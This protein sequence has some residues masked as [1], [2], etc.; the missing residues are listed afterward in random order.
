MN[1]IMLSTSAS[2]H[3]GPRA[4]WIPLASVAQRHGVSVDVLCLHP[5]YVNLTTQHHRIDDVSIQHVAQMHVD[6]HEQP[7]RG[8]ALISTA[9]RASAQMARHTIRAHPDVIAIC[10]AQPINGLAA[11]IAHR[12]TGAQLILDV[13]DSEHESHQFAR[14]WHKALIARVEHTL[15]HMVTSTSVASQWH[16]QQLAAAGHR[17]LA[18]VPNGIAGIPSL[19]TRIA[20]LPAQYIAYVGRIAFNTHAVDLLI[21]A[22]PL[23]HTTL[24]LVIA[25]SGPDVAAM[26]QRIADH[27]LGARCIWLGHVT[28]TN[29]QAI[30]AH[31]HA[32]VDPVRDTP[33]AA[34]RYPLKIIESLTHG[35]PVITSPVGDRATMVGGHGLLVTAGDA[36]SL[37]RALDDIAAQPRW[38]RANGQAHIAHLT[39]DQIGPQWLAHHRLPT[40][41]R[42]AR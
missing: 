23:T 31:A 1:L 6:R 19:P 25:G 21:D 27:G 37:A 33:G 35:V 13:D 30:I 4:R 38:S 2:H 20:G 36:A 29:A 28:P 39:W 15:P 22:L 17:N 40:L 26:H 5:D 34:A 18:H 3:P 41:Q 10:K 7:L 9:L 24:P 32:T 42:G 14:A 8:L 12:R 16:L 11:L